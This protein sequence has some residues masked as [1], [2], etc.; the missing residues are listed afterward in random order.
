MRGQATHRA[1]TAPLCYQTVKQQ[2]APTLQVLHSDVADLS[3]KFLPLE[4]VLPLVSSHLDPRRVLQGSRAGTLRKLPGWRRRSCCC[5]GQAGCLIVL[6]ADRD[7][8]KPGTQAEMTGSGDSVAG[9]GWCLLRTSSL[10]HS[11]ALV[12]MELCEESPRR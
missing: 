4:P 12:A 9:H 10:L 2:D 11:A 8:C 7:P 5:S 1:P 6:P 3:D